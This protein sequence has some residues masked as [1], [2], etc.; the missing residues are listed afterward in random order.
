MGQMWGGVNSERPLWTVAA[1]TSKNG[2]AL[3]YF[4]FV[5]NFRYLRYDPKRNGILE[6]AR[7][8]RVGSTNFPIAQNEGN[9]L[10]SR[11]KT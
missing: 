10:T 7:S 4:M 6:V 2:Y 3:V 8:I 11:N 5:R 1:G 9:Q